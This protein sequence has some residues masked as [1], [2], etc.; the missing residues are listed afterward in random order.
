MSHATDAITGL[1][2][3]RHYIASGSADGVVRIYDIRKGQLA[4]IDLACGTISSLA[5][6]QDCESVLVNFHG[7]DNKAGGTIQ[8]VRNIHARINLF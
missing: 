6:S 3:R 7:Q 4:S 2:S 5:L 1:D 8:W